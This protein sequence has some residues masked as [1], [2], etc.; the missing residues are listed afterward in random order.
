MM[1]RGGGMGAPHL[2]WNAN[3]TIAEK[4]AIYPTFFSLQNTKSNVI[5]VRQ[6]GRLPRFFKKIK[7]ELWHMGDK[8]LA[9]LD[10]KWEILTKWER[11]FLQSGRLWLNC[12]DK[13]GVTL[14]QRSS[15]R[16]ARGHSLKAM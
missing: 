8:V 4:F 11:C 12:L 1:G 7:W 5:M 3:Y 6:S 13:M 15:A 2:T 9:M 14:C 16:E 10:T